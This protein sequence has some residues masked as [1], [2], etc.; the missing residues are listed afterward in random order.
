MARITIKSRNTNHRKLMYFMV[1]GPVVA[2]I[3]YLIINAF[4]DETGILANTLL[5]V[6]ASILLVIL[7]QTIDIKIGKRRPVFHEDVSLWLIP[8][9]IAWT[10]LYAFL[11]LWIGN[12]VEN[13]A[14]RYVALIVWL[15]FFIPANLYVFYI[16]SRYN[17][18]AEYLS[19]GWRKTPRAKREGYI[20]FRRLGL[21]SL[22]II[23]LLVGY[24][25]FNSY[26]YDHF[27]E[28]NR[29]VWPGSVRFDKG[30]PREDNLSCQAPP[31]TD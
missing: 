16:Y 27:I 21:R 30:S 10:I 31:Y 5:F 20:L 28:T 3:S 24:V 6:Y 8:I 9:G 18:I 14:D 26:I 15:W 22:A 25:S 7:P 11:V 1:M 12:Y 4:V 13:F 23:L 17:K 2:I 29:C 19:A